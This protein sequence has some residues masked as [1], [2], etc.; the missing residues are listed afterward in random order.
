MGQRRNQHA[1]FKMIKIIP[2]QKGGIRVYVSVFMC[3][4][5]GS[6]PPRPLPG[7][8]SPARVLP[9]GVEIHYAHN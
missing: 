8:S 9:L 3:L 2:F 5:V 7:P 4:R 6:P 1:I